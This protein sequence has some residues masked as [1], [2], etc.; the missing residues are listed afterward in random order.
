MCH[1]L[2]P[3]THKV[4]TVSDTKLNYLKKIK[5]CVAQENFQQF[6]YA[7]ESCWQRM[8]INKFWV[9]D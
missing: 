2:P 1:P 6:K 8:Q 4:Y 3:H 7:K 9:T 5:A